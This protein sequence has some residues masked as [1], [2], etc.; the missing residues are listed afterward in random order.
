M[1]AAC[2]NAYQLEM[3]DRICLDRQGEVTRQAEIRNHDLRHAYIHRRR[4]R[5]PETMPHHPRLDLQQ[6]QYQDQ[7]LVCVYYVGDESG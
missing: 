7:D 1:P 6:V 4:I 3:D 5:S 2:Q